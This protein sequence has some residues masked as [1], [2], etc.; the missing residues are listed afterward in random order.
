MTSP[1]DCEEQDKNGCEYLSVISVNNINISY[2]QIKV[3]DD[4]DDVQ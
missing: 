4:D 1:D 2:K 3:D